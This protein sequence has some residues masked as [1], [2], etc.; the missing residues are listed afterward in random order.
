MAKTFIE[1]LTDEQINE[2]LKENFLEIEKGN[3]KANFTK[4]KLHINVVLAN[5]SEPN[6]GSFSFALGNFGTSNCPK[7]KAW[8]KYLYEIFGREYKE[9][10]LEKCAEIFE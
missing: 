10:Y 6:N 9:A 2:F 3:Y 8:I 4:T 5:S 1:R 7:H